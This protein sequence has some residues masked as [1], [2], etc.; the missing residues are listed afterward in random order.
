MLLLAACSQR[1]FYRPRAA[2]EPLL[3][4][5]LHDICPWLQPGPHGNAIFARHL[6]TDDGAACA[7]GAGQIAELEGTSGQGLA[8]DGIVIAIGNP[9]L[10]LPS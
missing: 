10:L 8:G 9:P 1:H 7:A 4:A 3:R 2:N 6:L 5:H